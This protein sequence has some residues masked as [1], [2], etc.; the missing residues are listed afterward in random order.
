MM[1]GPRR[2]SLGALALCVA[3][4]AGGA[5]AADHAP[6]G[7]G[8]GGSVAA[9]LGITAPGLSARTLA[10]ALRAYERARTWGVVQRPILSIIDYALPSTAER[11]WVLDLER[12]RVLFHERVAH[13]RGSGENEARSFSNEPGSRQSSLGAFRTGAAY[14]G[15]HGVSLRLEGLEPGIND[16]ACERE[17]VL[18]GASYVSA[19]FA[20]RRG[21]IGRSFGCPAVRT[22]IADRLIRAIQG[23]TL[24]VACYPDSACA[25]H[26]AYLGP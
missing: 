11:L 18:H 25:A 20:A 9:S 21:R 14:V 13:G 24:L 19:A 1:R 16:L 23:G 4:A 8:A 5:L 17:I 26:S 15:K 7:G 3:I 2:R 22:A 6:A 10:L 12:D